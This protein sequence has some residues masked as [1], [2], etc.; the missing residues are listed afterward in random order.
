MKTKEHYEEGK[1]I[2]ADQ[3]AAAAVYVLSTPPHVQVNI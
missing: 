2:G 3:I 1:I